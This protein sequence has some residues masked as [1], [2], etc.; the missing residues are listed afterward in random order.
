MGRIVRRWGGRRGERRDESECRGGGGDYISVAI[1]LFPWRLLS[2]Q[3]CKAATEQDCTAQA[4]FSKLFFR[5]LH[6]DSHTVA[7]VPDPPS[8][9]VECSKI[10]ESSHRRAQGPET[11][12]FRMQDHAKLQKLAEFLNLTRLLVI[13]VSFRSD[14]QALWPNR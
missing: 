4:F 2:L 14:S 3:D 5:R 7:R 8:R 6:T 1:T 13:A 10:K 11:R 12:V 9:R